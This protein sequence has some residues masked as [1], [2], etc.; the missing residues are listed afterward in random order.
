M[1]LGGNLL[2]ES[3]DTPIG[4]TSGGVQIR[5]IS[6]NIAVAEIRSGAM[7]SSGD[8][9]GIILEALEGSVTASSRLET[10]SYGVNSG[11]AG[12]LSIKALSD[13]QLN[14]VALQA[15]CA[16]E[17]GSCSAGN[18]G[19]FSAIS[20]SGSIVQIPT[21]I[22]T[23]TSSYANGDLGSTS[24]DGGAISF[25][26]PNGTIDLEGPLFSG[27]RGDSGAGNGGM[28]S[29]QAGGDIT[30]LDSIESWVDQ[31]IGPVV[32][33]GDIAI[34]TPAV[35]EVS[36]LDASAT[37][38][39]TSPGDV[40]LAFG[41]V[42]TNGA[43]S[44]GELTLK[45]YDPAADIGVGTLATPAWLDDSQLT[46]L[47]TEFE[48]LVIGGPDS[49]GLVTVD[50]T[51]PALQKPLV[52]RSPSSSSSGMTIG[53]L[54]DLTGYSLTLEAGG[55]T[56]T[57]SEPIVVSSLALVG[58][59]TYSLTNPLNQVP[60]LKG[61]SAGPT[62]LYTLSGLDLAG[63]SFGSLFVDAG[64][65][66]IGNSGALS[67][68]AA[69]VRVAS[70]QSITLTHPGNIF[71]GVLSVGASSG[72]VSQL[73]VATAGQLNMAAFSL[74]GNISISAAG[75]SQSSPW[76]VAGSANLVAGSGGISL[77]QANNFNSVSLLSSGTVGLTDRDS[78]TL[79]QVN[80]E[81]N[82]QLSAQGNIVQTAPLLVSASTQIVGGAGLSLD[83]SNP[84]NVL[85]GP[86]A[87]SA[88]SGRLN[89]VDVTNSVP[90][91]L[92]GVDI[93]GRLTAVAP[94]ISQSGPVIAD[95][96]S[97]LTAGPG[98]IS[99]LNNGNRLPNL[100]LQSDHN[101]S[102]Y[103]LGSVD[104]SRSSIVN[105][106][107]LTAEGGIT[108]SGPL[109]VGGLLTLSSGELFDITLT[110]P[111][112]EL[113][114]V[115]VTQGFNVSLATRGTLQVDSLN[116]NGDLFIDSPGGVSGTGAYS[117][118]GQ[119]LFT[120]PNGTSIALNN[121]DNRFTVA[122]QFEVSD[123]L[124]D[125][126]SIANALPL[127][128]PALEVGGDLTVSAPGISQ[129]GPI[130]VEGLASF[131]AG[132]EPLALDNQDNQ[133]ARLMVESGDATIMTSQPLSI[134][135]ATVSGNLLARAFSGDISAPGAVL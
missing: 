100:A 26:A 105:N 24:G 48:T 16:V 84:D 118:A 52:I 125:N 14:D 70:G 4:V 79:G 130:Q 54:P 30:L 49:S 121:P 47:A 43:S 41:S 86:I 63:G 82:F 123:G 20:Q 103:S 116:A 36:G 9:G 88:S 68:G 59:A 35:L 104:L 129:S 3:Y 112:N 18:G 50:T 117:V 46:L 115:S 44:G 40:S 89:S 90:L 126:L 33:A 95:S 111:G 124:L 74:L 45:P 61:V 28:V 133:I 39:N 92:A 85:V 27:S 37:G 109:T 32:R 122:P 77:S 64:G 93:S 96:L 81:G 97:Q 42:L 102:L 120:V 58:G 80:I 108:Q 101:A 34:E 114:Q 134:E 110:N 76:D 57:Q 135:Q 75:I 55:G 127:T 62:N 51:V 60:F 65:G 1:N 2:A 78:I 12:D 25:S 98:G 132:T 22:G 13:I 128:L 8:G 67:V 31:A 113:D 23:D 99:L 5:S 15:S 87:L 66:S 107:T 6:G 7:Q 38:V 94:A 69:S 106:L 10:T 131:F 21:W 83:L 19:S 53:S 72:S 119:A 73:D 71:S 11:N 29:L 91:V 17:A 56:V